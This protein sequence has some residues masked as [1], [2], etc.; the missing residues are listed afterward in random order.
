M[1]HAHLLTLLMGLALIIGCAAGP[2]SRDTGQQALDAPGALRDGP[3][4]VAGAGSGATVVYEVG[5]RAADEADAVGAPRWNGGLAGVDPGVIP[6]APGDSRFEAGV[7]YA[8]AYYPSPSGVETERANSL[9][10]LYG[11]ARPGYGLYTFVLGGPVGAS[12]DADADA[13][14]ELL[15]VIETYVLNAPAE[16]ERE[17]RHG[18]LIQ[19]DPIQLTD[20]E[21]AELGLA[22]LARPGLSLQMQTVLARQLRMFGLPALADRLEHSQGPFLVTSLQPGLIPL[23]EPKPLLI[24]DLHDLGPEYM[25]SLVDAYDRPIPPDLVGRPASLSAIGRRIQA[26]FPNR[27]VDSG[28]APPPSGEWIW[29]VG[30]PGQSDRLRAAT[31]PEES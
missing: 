14:Q 15:R 21:S 1:R 9:G 11:D 30:M 22:Q 5:D 2:G 26:M 31:S 19:V 25:Y 28:A 6:G 12:S 4:E 23:S 7:L 17:G 16:N 18:F 29:M 27:R 24:V 3:S 8:M 20:E 13:Y 10:A